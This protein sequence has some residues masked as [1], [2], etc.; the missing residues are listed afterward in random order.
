MKIA[1]ITAALLFLSVDAA[2]PLHRLSAQD[3][4]L[5]TSQSISWVNWTSTQHR[6]HASHLLT[7]EEEERRRAYRLISFGVTL[8]LFFIC[9]VCSVMLLVIC[10]ARWRSRTPAPAR[11]A[12]GGVVEKPHAKGDVVSA[13]PF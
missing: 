6:A 13:T 10:D 2:P 3:T 5:V 1:K 7:A 9:C 8:T 11:P 4:L 12:V